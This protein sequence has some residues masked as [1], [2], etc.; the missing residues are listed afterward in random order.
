[1]TNAALLS[2]LKRKKACPEA[3]VWVGTR[4]LATAWRECERADWML[5]LCGIMAGTKN[6]PTRQQVVLAAAACARQA[7][8][9]VLTT[10]ER[11]LAAIEA[12]E[13]WARMPTTE[14][15]QAP[16]PAR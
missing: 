12:A 11:P 2:L 10:E 3:V 5:W 4:D 1:M 7:L 13:V 16:L 9:F 8:R 14:A 6:W 15:A